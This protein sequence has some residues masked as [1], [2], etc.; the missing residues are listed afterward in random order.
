M[1]TQVKI[2][3]QYMLMHSV[4]NDTREMEDKI[5]AFLSDPDIRSLGTPINLV[6]MEDG[7]CLMTATC[8]YY[9]LSEIPKK[10]A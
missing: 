8:F 7:L 3:K 4:Q 10:K 1:A 6:N 9:R 2:F 5:N